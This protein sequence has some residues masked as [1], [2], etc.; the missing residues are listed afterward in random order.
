MRGE[1]L[2]V[3]DLEL[4]AG[5]G[6]AC[7]SEASDILSLRRWCGRERGDVQGRSRQEGRYEGEDDADIH[8]PDAIE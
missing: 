3:F 6:D 5:C 2:W 7:V 4:E 8:Y 1:R